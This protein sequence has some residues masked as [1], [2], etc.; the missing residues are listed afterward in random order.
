MLPSVVAVATQW[1]R[2]ILG[3]IPYTCLL[4][5]ADNSVRRW[6]RDLSAA[7]L[8][9]LVLPSVTSGQALGM[10]VWNGGWLRIQGIGV[11]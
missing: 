4:G 1:Q 6:W 2:Q 10:T 8:G 9:A 7:L 11:V 3:F 5:F